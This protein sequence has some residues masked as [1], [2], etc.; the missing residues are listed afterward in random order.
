MTYTVERDTY[1]TATWYVK[2]SKGAVIGAYRSR[3][4]AEKAA[5]K[6]GA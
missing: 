3:A 6:A 1:G 4:A 2:N 5:A